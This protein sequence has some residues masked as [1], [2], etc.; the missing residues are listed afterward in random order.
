MFKELLNDKM[1]TIANLGDGISKILKSNA[2][3]KITEHNKPFNCDILPN[4]IGLNGLM[5]DSP[6]YKYK[7]NTH[8]CGLRKINL[9]RTFELNKDFSLLN[10]DEQDSILNELIPILKDRFTH[11]YKIIEKRNSFIVDG[12]VENH[13]DYICYGNKVGY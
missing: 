1:E 13:I 6:I 4:E 7:D 2:V 12:Y 3:S 11:I 8:Q 10:Q 5:V 9:K